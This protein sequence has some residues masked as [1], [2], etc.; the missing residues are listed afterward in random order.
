MKHMA[1]RTHYALLAGTV[2][3][4]AAYFASAALYVAF[5][6]YFVRWHGAA[7]YGQFSILLNTVSALTLF[8]NYHGA[9]VSY[10]V[11]GDRSAYR[12]FRRPVVLYSVLASLVA[13]GVLM[14]VGSLPAAAAPLV[15]ASF[16]L[17]VYSGLPASTIMATP[18]NYL[19]NLVRVLYQVVLVLAFWPLFGTS[20][21]VG[22][23]FTVALAAAAALNAGILTFLSR[24]TFEWRDG[25]SSA[26]PALLLAAL[27]GNLAMMTTMLLDKFVLRFIEPGTAQ[28]RGLFLLYIDL[29]GRLSAIFNVLLPTL[30]YLLLRRIA[31]RQSPA[32]PIA[33]AT[34]LSAGV[35]A[36]AL[37]G[38]YWVI[39]FIYGV[40]LQGV[41]ALPGSMAAYI[42]LY[43]LSSIV[44]AFC[45]STGR[46]WYLSGH[47][48]AMLLVTLAVISWPIAVMGRALTIN[49]LALAVAAGQGVALVS[50]AVLMARLRYGSE[51]KGLIR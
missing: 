31:E 35:G 9:I 17:L 36:G 46:I 11:T 40:S 50:A 45:N 30:T 3:S 16:F 1:P 27:I 42:G 14:L 43:G 13:T 39:P 18:S 49:D 19:L 2:L 21:E 33:L 48:A 4:F 51:R 10:S 41:E 15:L 23:S 8:G 37:I 5:S 44:L 28:E 6:V 47:Y 20:H 26:K 34:L 22:L 29:I 32:Q 12:D 38:G 24:Q 7:A 25:A